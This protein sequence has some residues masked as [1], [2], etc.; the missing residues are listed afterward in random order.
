MQSD[1]HLTVDR[2]AMH[3]GQQGRPAIQLYQHLAQLAIERCSR[4]GGVI[5]VGLRIIEW[6]TTPSS[7]WLSCWF[8]WCCRWPAAADAGAEAGA[9]AGDVTGDQ[10]DPGGTTRPYQHCKLASGPVV[11]A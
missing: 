3:F 5:V 2:T 8:M 4:N 11:A 9:S 1:Q 6:R 7:V 10:G